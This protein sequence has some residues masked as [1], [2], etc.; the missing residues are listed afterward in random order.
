MIFRV[1][2]ISVIY[3]V[4]VGILRVWNIEKVKCVYVRKELIGRVSD[5]EEEN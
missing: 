3:F 4:Y 2:C 5:N 1:V